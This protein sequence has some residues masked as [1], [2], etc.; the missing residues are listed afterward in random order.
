MAKTQKPRERE[1]RRSESG[2][3]EMMIASDENIFLPHPA[4]VSC[5]SRQEQIIENGFA[6]LNIR[7]SFRCWISGGMKKKFNLF[8][9]LNI[10][11]CNPMFMLL[12]P[13][14]LCFLFPIIM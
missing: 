7:I 5:L 10:A 14:M 2:S 1:R 13:R 4:P 9:I 6:L 3:D 12:F 8:F 11:S